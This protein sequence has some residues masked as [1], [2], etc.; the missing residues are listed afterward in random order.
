MPYLYNAFLVDVEL[1]FLHQQ[2]DQYK[3]VAK[4]IQ[5]NFQGKAAI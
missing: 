2:M 5:L 3:L 1:S 4:S